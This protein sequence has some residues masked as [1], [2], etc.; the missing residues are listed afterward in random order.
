MRTRL[1]KGGLV[2]VAAV[3]AI[4]AVSWILNAPRDDIQGVWATDGYGLY[5]DVGRIVIDVYQV[6]EV[7]CLRDMRI[8]GHL[9]AVKA[10]EGVSFEKEGDRLRLDVTGSLNPIH[11]DRAPALPAQ[12]GTTETP[13]TLAENFAVFWTA[14]SEHYPF[15][16][17]HGVDWGGCKTPSS[18][19]LWQS[20][21]SAMDGLDDGH[22][23]IHDGEQ[24]HSPSV[25]PNWYEDRHA[26]RDA[27][28]ASIT[29]GLIKIANTGL[30]IGSAS[31]DVA[32]IH[33]EDMDTD[34]PFGRLPSDTA[35]RAMAEVV[36]AFPRARAFI[37]DVRYNPG[38]SDDIALAYAGFFAKTPTPAFSKS[39]RTRNGFT[40]ETKV[41][42]QPGPLYVD[43]PVYLLTSGFTGSAAEIFTLAMREMPNVT[44]MGTPTG[45]GLSDVLNFRLPNG[46]EL[47]LSHQIYLAPDGSAFEGVGIP[48][49][50]TLPV[51]VSAYKAG[52]DPLI[53]AALAEFATTQ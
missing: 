27:T 35:T 10:L 18:N 5:L 6:T 42:T 9:W 29:G 33:I 7:S 2:A 23:Y 22:L 15:F 32:Y 8:P 39:T 37:I 14:M 47:G 20:I 50:V 45:G 51:D 31:D 28:R 16:D 49:D 26:V 21:T 41:M 4:I 24:V 11:A 44:T 30:W 12:C 34:T 40:A 19:D 52:H 53:A 38:G 43:K 13:G 48:P 1:L 25:P 36:A 46:W 3:I 17:L